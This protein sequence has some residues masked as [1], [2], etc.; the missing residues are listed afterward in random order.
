MSGRIGT[1]THLIYT[2]NPRYLK[3]PKPPRVAG[4]VSRRKAFF[5]STVK[6]KKWYTKDAQHGATARRERV[7]LLNSWR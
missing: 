1:A 7:R 6:R 3:Q 2:I 5:A 4:K